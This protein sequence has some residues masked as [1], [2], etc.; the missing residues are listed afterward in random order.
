MSYLRSN[1]KSILWDISS[2]I[3]WFISV[4]GI[5]ITMTESPTRLL[6]NIIMEHINYNMATIT[7]TVGMITNRLKICSSSLITISLG[8]IHAMVFEPS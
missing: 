3:S 1:K 7:I 2:T 6:L 4:N 5:K 8:Q